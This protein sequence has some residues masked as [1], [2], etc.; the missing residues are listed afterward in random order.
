MPLPSDKA[1]INTKPNAARTRKIFGSQGDEEAPPGS[2]RS[3]QSVVFGDGSGFVEGEDG[4]EALYLG[5][6]LPDFAIRTERTSETDRILSRA[7]KK[8]AAR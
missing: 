4:L 3:S 6:D 2:G 1:S 8:S 7:L 5:V